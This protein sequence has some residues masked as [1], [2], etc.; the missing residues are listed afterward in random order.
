MI[1]VPCGVTAATS[2]VEKSDLLIHCQHAIDCLKEAGYRCRGD[3]RDNYSPGWKFNHWELKARHYILSLV[4]R[5][6]AGGGGGGGGGEPGTHCS[7][8]RIISPETSP[9]PLIVRGWRG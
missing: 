7:R 5:L 6:F 8:M 4:P 9:F 2:E 3:F 1:V